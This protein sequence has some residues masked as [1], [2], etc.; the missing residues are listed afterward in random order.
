MQHQ[1]G[2]HN[3]R[4]ILAS[5]EKRS[6]AQITFPPFIISYAFKY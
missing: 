4:K 1:I 2:E 5:F 6:S 3:S